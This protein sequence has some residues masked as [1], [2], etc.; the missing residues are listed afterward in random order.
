MCVGLGAQRMAWHGMDGG[1]AWHSMAWVNFGMAWHGAPA[2]VG[3]AWANFSHGMGKI[4]HGM[5]WA[6]FGMAWAN[7]GTAW[8]GQFYAWHG[9]AT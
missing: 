2:V 3:M 7:P 9:M 6:T 8:H 5:T 1:S 4:R